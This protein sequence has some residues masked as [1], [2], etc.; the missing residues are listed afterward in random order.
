MEG[1]LQSLPNGGK[2]F[3]TCGPFLGSLHPWSPSTCSFF[4]EYFPGCTVNTAILKEKF[5]SVFSNA[6]W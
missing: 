3:S 5:L 6:A 4:D 2:V 1:T